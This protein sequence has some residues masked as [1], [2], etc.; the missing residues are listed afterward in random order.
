MPVSNNEKV[1]YVIKSLL[2]FITL[3]I[4]ISGFSQQDIDEA[5]PNPAQIKLQEQRENMAKNK[6]TKRER[7]TT[8]SNQT[9]LLW[10][11]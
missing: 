7:T 10:N 9:P 3:F 2:V 5:N 6:K 8:T 1:N 4:S 11:L